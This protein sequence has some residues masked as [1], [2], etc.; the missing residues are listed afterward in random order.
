MTPSESMIVGQVSHRGIATTRFVQRLL[1]L[2]KPLKPL[3]VVLKQLL[4][5]KGLNDAYK[6]GLGSYGLTIMAAAVIQR[7]TLEPIKPTMGALLVSFLQ[8]YSTMCFDT[9]RF[10]VALSPDGPLAALA[11][12]YTP[13][14]DTSS[15][16]HPAPPVVILDPLNHTENVGRTCF[17]FRQ[18]QRCFDDALQTISGRYQLA[19]SGRAAPSPAAAAGSPSGDTSLLGAV[20]GAAHHHHVV[21]LATSIWCPLEEVQ[22]STPAAPSDAGSSAVAP[23]SAVMNDLAAKTDGE[24]RELVVKLASEA[25]DRAVLEDAVRL[26]RR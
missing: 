8:T 26:L 2:H 12:P 14:V 6:G 19:L 21:K 24:L 11:P 4:V 10:C 20:F 16:W 13:R 25:H 23:S 15:Y 22:S 9:R 7:H 1:A 3:V 5:E 17:G 18:V